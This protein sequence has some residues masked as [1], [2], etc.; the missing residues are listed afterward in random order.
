MS[1]VAAFLAFLAV[2]TT[3]ARGSSVDAF[4]GTWTGE[5][6]GIPLVLNISGSDA[7]PQAT[8]SF[9][10]GPTETFR[11]LGYKDAIPGLYFWREADKA[12]VCLFFD[13]KGL[14]MAYFERDSVRRVPLRRSAAAQPSAPA[15]TAKPATSCTKISEC[16]SFADVYRTDT[17]FRDRLLLALRSA[18]IPKP[19]WLTNGLATSMV[20]LLMGD[21]NY[22]FG[23]VCE[24]HN[25]PHKITVLYSAAQQ[26][27]VGQYVPDTGLE[28]WFGSPTSTEQ[29]LINESHDGGS[30]FRIRMEQGLLPVVIE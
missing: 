15:P 5:I 19:T 6:S 9:N 30:S 10:R 18:Q 23:S 20:P 1:R 4:I 28:R 12:A 3:P 8:A 26:R 2:L 14:W 11:Y 21:T 13:R 29:K 16:P 22:L 17:M 25:C 7:A 27:L 24:P